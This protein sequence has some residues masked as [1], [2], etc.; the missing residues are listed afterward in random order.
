MLDIDLIESFLNT[1]DVRNA[2]PPTAQSA[3]ISI[4]KNYN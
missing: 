2:T 4:A 1:I 3:I